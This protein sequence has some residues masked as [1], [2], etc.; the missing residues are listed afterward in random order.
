MESKIVH[1]RLNNLNDAG[2]RDALVCYLQYL[3]DY[4]RDVPDMDDHVI[5][6]L[7]R[8]FSTKYVQNLRDNDPIRHILNSAEE[9]EEADT[10]SRQHIWSTLRSNILSLQ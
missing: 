3:M 1:E 4:R 2:A 10:Q 6:E 5:S 9:L 8:L 7:Q